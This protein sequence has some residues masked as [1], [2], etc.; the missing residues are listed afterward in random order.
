MTK[1]VGTIAHVLDTFGSLVVLPL[2]TLLVTADVVLRYVFLKPLSWGLEV[3]SHLLLVFFLLGLAQSFRAGD[4][5]S[6]ELVAA[7][8]PRRGRRVIALVQAALVVL[9]FYFILAKTIEE[10]PF[11]YS[12]PQLSPELN[13]PVWPVYAFIA[14]ISALVILYVVGAAIAIVRGERDTIEEIEGVGEKH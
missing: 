13:W 5:I 9:I 4:H 7:Q 3:S 12:L 14:F 10:I 2:L 11:L 6:M 1:I 8:I